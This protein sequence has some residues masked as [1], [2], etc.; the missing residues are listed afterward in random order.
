MSTG[1]D[2][3][4]TNETAVLTPDRLARYADAV[5]RSCLRLDPGDVLFVQGQPGHR[6]LM[7]ALVEAAYRAG[8]AQANVE[9][10][11]NLVAAARIRLAAD[12]HLG[13][14][15]DWAARRLRAQLEP[16]S[17][18]VTIVGEGDPGAF[19]RLPSG[20]IVADSQGRI[21][22]MQWFLRATRAGRYRWTGCAWPTPYWAGQ[23][24]PDLDP[25]EAMRQLAEDLLWF[26]RL[27]PDDPPDAEGWEAHVDAIARRGETLTELR[28]ERLELRGPGTQLDVRLPEHARWLGG[29]E[30]NAHGRLVAPN[31]PTEENFTSPTP[32]ATSG[33][34]R[35]S[36]PLSFRGRLI[37]GIAGEFRGGRLVRLEAGDDADRELL[38]AFL[39]SDP[40]ASRLGEVALVDRTSR[41]GR[42]ERL[43]ANTLIDENAAAHIAFGY[44]F[45]QTRVSPPLG[46]R[47]QRVNSS[48]LHLDVMIGTDDLEVTGFAA[49][50]RAIPL[51]RGGE[52]QI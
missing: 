4:P 32:G 23:V 35:C 16:R 20:R 51:L 42:M 1:T 37:D 22:K 48:N 3:A 9:Y 10:L 25:A 45:D 29:R 13:P 39:D 5:V 27:G 11:D 46:G 38:A 2:A 24:Y 6:E 19:D 14:L 34:F 50:G 52:W 40:G 12:E 7:V 8:A 44:G 43:Y 36:R 21:G 18:S 17:A 49:G 33:T 47:A 26:C 15:P 41:I 28:L 31:F 30:L